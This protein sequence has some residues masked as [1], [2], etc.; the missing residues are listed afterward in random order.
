MRSGLKIGLLA[1]ATAVLALAIWTAC[2]GDSTGNAP[3]IPHDVT[4]P[5]DSSCLSCHKDGVG[6]AP[7]TPHPDRTGCTECHKK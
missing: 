4:S 3:A 7:K 6:G 1:V 5:D 2:G